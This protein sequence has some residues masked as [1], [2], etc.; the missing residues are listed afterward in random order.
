MEKLIGSIIRRCELQT[1][2]IERMFEL[3][4]KYYDNVHKDRFISDLQ[5]K[6]WILLLEEKT[7][8]IIQGF[9]T[10][11]LMKVI[12]NG[13]PVRC[14][15]SGDTIIDEAFRGQLE[16]IK[17]WLDFAL[18]SLLNKE[19]TKLYWF[20]ISKGYKTYKFFPLFFPH[21]YP[22]YDQKNSMELKEILDAF[23]SKKFPDEY[24]AAHGVIKPKMAD[25]LKHGKKEINEHRLK[26][27]HIK[28][29]VERNP[30]F[31][32]GEELCCLLEIHWDN[33]TRYGKKLVKPKV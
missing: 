5:E 26:D 17:V 16:L 33:L 4:T 25:W 10:I 12:I 30:N 24:D 28:F 3:M 29:F 11:M 6:E 23:A 22:G 13:K 18:N 9:T 15:F 8:S 19:E 27:P 21:Y 7:T 14:I 32:K 31:W 1:C 20:L 2:Q